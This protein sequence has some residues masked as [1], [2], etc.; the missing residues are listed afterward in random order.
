M[1][2]GRYLNPDRIRAE[3]FNLVEEDLKGAEEVLENIVSLTLGSE[4]FFMLDRV[5][6]KMG[7]PRGSI[8]RHYLILYYLGIIWLAPGKTSENRAGSET[9]RLDLSSSFWNLRPGDMIALGQKHS[10]EEMAG[11]VPMAI[12]LALASESETAEEGEKEA[13]RGLLQAMMAEDSLSLR[14]CI[15][16]LMVK[17]GIYDISMGS[18]GISCGY[19]CDFFIRLGCDET[20]LDSFIGGMFLG[21]AGF[22]RAG[23]K[24]FYKYKSR[25][26]F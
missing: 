8:T 24:I 22:D 18:Y 13:V 17:K 4:Y 15:E 12:G 9:I 10:P 1:S 14:E 21:D 16:V 5:E 2:K 23:D 25:K 20:I 26:S 7:A 6:E 19:L 11:N 3:G